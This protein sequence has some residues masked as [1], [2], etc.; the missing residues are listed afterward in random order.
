M[1][2]DRAFAAAPRISRREVTLPKTPDSSPRNLAPLLL[3]GLLPLGVVVALATTRTR[4][5]SVGAMALF[6]LLAPLAVLITF[7]L[8]GRQRAARQR[9][10]GEEKDEAQRKL[11]GYVA[12][13]ERQRRNLAPD[14]VAQVDGRSHEMAT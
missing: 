7:K 8:E 9:A 5:G 6:A 1:D 2:F 11:D 4:G 3:P 14:Q 10:Y 12:A 13:E